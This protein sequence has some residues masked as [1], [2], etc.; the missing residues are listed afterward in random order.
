MNEAHTKGKKWLGQ[1][2]ARASITAP[3]IAEGRDRGMFPKGYRWGI[4]KEG[5]LCPGG[6]RFH[7][8]RATVANPRTYPPNGREVRRQAH[9]V[10]FPNR[11]LEPRRGNHSPTENTEKKEKAIRVGKEEGFLPPAVNAT[12]INR[13]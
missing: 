13:M 4:V 10:Q 8:G 3:A 11:R 9:I 5:W 12:S 7:D 6:R 2:K 1:Y